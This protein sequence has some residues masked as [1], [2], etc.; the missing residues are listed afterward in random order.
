MLNQWYKS[1]IAIPYDIT[2][3]QNTTK[4]NKFNKLKKNSYYLEAQSTCCGGWYKL[5]ASFI[6]GITGGLADELVDCGDKL[7][8]CEMFDVKDDTD[9]G[10]GG[11]VVYGCIT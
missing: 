8:P 6:E 3:S 1:S 9:D 7:D 2:A 5:T 11:Y 10:C 4:T